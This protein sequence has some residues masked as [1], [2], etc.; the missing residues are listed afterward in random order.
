MVRNKKT[1]IKLLSIIFCL[2]LLFTGPLSSEQ[3]RSQDFPGFKRAEGL[4]AAV[5]SPF[6]YDPNRTLN[7]DPKIIDNYAKI[8][9][10]DGVKMVLVSGTTGESL[11]MSLEER[12]VL[13]KLWVDSARKYGIDVYIH[14][15]D[16][17]LENARK[18]AMQAESL[19]V[20]AV[21][22]MPPEY[23]KPGSIEALVDTM[24][25]IAEAAPK[26]P[27]YYYHI[28]SM[29]GVDFRMIDFLKAV[30]SSGKIPNFVGIKFTDT[31]LQDYFECVLYDDGRYDIL[32]GLDEQLL[33]ALAMGAKGAVGSTY[34]FNGKN[35]NA[36]IDAFKAFNLPKAQAILAVEVQLVDLID[37]TYD[38]YNAGKAIMEMKGVKVGPPRLP[39]F[40]LSKEQ[41]EQLKKAVEELGILN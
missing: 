20:A 10:A 8:L 29:T 32:Y 34:N 7:S 6:R 2:S 18:L 23:F 38:G 5:F 17:C 11:S 31:V 14:V 21:V 16:N 12:Q 36:L 41:F 3:K 13:S 30:V 40:I 37:V 25:Y 9:A 15:G 27:F 26:T 35:M 4:M 19:G 28:P 24:A 39:Y 22:A 33:G 1:I